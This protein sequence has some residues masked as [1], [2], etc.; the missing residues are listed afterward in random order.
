MEEHYLNQLLSPH[1][2]AVVGA[3]DSIDSIGRLV[4]ENIL[5][6]K[7]SGLLFPVN[8]KHSVVQGHIAYSSIDEISNTIDLAII[9]TPAHTVPEIITQCGKKGEVLNENACHVDE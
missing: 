5:T 1:S 3:S 6:G 8:S 4:F 7:Y 9:T 2:I